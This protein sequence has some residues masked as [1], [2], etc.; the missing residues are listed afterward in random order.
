[1]IDNQAFTLLDEVHNTTDIRSQK[2]VCEYKQ[3]TDFII[4]Y[5]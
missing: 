4:K 3:L 2:K 1:L 5:S